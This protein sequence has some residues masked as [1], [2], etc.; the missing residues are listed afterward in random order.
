MK[1]KTIKAIIWT[2][3]C[4]SNQSWSL[5]ED[6]KEDDGIM[7]ITILTVG[8]IVKATELYIS[9]AQSYGEDTEQFCNVMTIP[10]GCIINIKDIEL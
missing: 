8:F 3:S 10:R 6:I 7:P 2:D 4:T 1:K 9:V 5:A